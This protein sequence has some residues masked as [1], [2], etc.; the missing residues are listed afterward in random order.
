MRRF[1]LSFVVLGACG[2]SA[3]TT[4]TELTPP[5]TSPGAKIGW[6]WAAGDS[7]YVYGED[8]HTYRTND[9]GATWD[10]FPFHWMGVSND[11]KTIY[12]D[13]GSGDGQRST[14]G[15]QTWTSHPTQ[16]DVY[17]IG[18]DPDVIY[19]FISGFTSSGDPTV[20]PV[21]SADG[22][23]TNVQLSDNPTSFL[24]D[25]FVG[26]RMYYVDQQSDSFG[27]D[28][29]DDM[30]QTLTSISFAQGF[31]RLDLGVKDALWRFDGASLGHSTDAGSTWTP[32]GD[33]PATIQELLSAVDGTAIAFT[34]DGTIS[35]VTVDDDWTPIGTTPGDV[36][37]AYL[38][39]TPGTAFVVPPG[40]SPDHVY[41]T[42]D[43]GD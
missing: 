8:F 37:H 28:R 42:Q 6:V 32:V 13:T 2:S 23:A 18:V 15:G 3:T 43:L 35:R 36:G 5:S 1:L 33:G 40:D 12:A 16:I 17:A 34:A 31:V 4:W 20:F 21:R 22:G 19:G 30:G 14:D 9:A 11:G 29:S 41:A 38:G 39:A 7:L 10:A 24:A 27:Y 26:A 25:P